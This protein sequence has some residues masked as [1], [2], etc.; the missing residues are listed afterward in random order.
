VIQGASPLW[1][2]YRGRKRF[3][4]PFYLRFWSRRRQGLAGKDFGTQTR[5]VSV[6]VPCITLGPQPGHW[7]LK[8]GVYLIVALSQV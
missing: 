2:H 4:Y 6:C 3:Q 5:A 8:A 1:F 7:P